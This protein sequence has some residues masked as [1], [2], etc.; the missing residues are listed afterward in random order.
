MVTVSVLEFG[1][2]ASRVSV[3]ARACGLVAPVFRSP[4]AA[5]GVRRSLRRLPDGPAVVAVR[6][7]GT[8]VATLVEDLVDGTLAAN[9]VAGPEADVLRMRIRSLCDGP[10]DLVA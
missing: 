5:P 2:L 6:L 10:V 4:P 8:T 9:R 1:E 3:A 7:R